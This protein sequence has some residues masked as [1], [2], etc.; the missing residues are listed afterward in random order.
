VR[1]CARAAAAAVGSAPS[2]G[3]MLEAGHLESGGLAVGMY[4]GAAGRGPVGGISSGSFSGVREMIVPCH[5]QS[6]C[7]AWP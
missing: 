5:L 7:R 3:M 6:A 1:A 4:S 2:G